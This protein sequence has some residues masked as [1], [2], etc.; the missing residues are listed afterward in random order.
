MD[1]QD[2]S[3]VPAIT[4]VPTNLMIEMYKSQLEKAKAEVQRLESNIK[5]LNES[6]LTGVSVSDYDMIARSI[7]WRKAIRYCLTGA[8]QLL[9]SVDIAEFIALENRLPAADRNIKMKVSTTLSLM[10]AE[11][12]VGRVS[13]A[14]GDRDYYYGFIDYFSDDK[15]TLKS[16]FVNML[17]WE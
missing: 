11:G 2:N 17:K 4:T 10:F 9:R 8:K 3:L 15:E 12:K 1:K 14:N 5:I 6:M 16:E 13:L 7:K